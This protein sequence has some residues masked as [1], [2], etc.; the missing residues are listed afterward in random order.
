MTQ[1]HLITGGIR[2]GKSEYAEQLTLDDAS[3]KGVRPLYIAT[4]KV[5]DEAMR[6]RVALHQRRR[7]DRWDLVEEST[8]PART[9]LS[10]R[11]ILLDCLTLWL[12]NI[13][14]ENDED[15]TKSIGLFKENFLRLLD[16]GADAIYIVTN[17]I[18]FGGVPANAVQRKFADLQGWANQ[19]VAREAHSVTMMISGLPLKVK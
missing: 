19:I 2:S 12:T 18:G 14:F 1:I 17:E 16:T 7:A 4:A 10:G 11:I 9:D 13:F 5:Y 3:R 6:Q 15:I 8:D